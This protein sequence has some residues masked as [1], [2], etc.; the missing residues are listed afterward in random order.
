MMHRHNVLYHL[1]K[2]SIPYGFK[3]VKVQT[4]NNTSYHK[5]SIIT[6][7]MINEVI[8]KIKA[9]TL[10]SIGNNIGFRNQGT[11]KSLIEFR[12]SL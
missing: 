3:T 12:D 9:K 11:V 7:D 6:K 1:N 4:D 2:H 10:D 5:Q 8:K